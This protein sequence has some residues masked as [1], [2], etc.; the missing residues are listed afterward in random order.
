[1]KYYCEECKEQPMLLEVSLTVVIQ[2]KWDGKDYVAY[3]TQE[4]PDEIVVCQKCGMIVEEVPDVNPVS[5]LSREECNKETLSA[6]DFD[7][8]ESD[9]ME[10]D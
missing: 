2:K 9:D 3:A 4:Q 7:N 5:P 8:E 10:T 1:M 6:E